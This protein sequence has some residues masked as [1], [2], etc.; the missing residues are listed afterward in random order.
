MTEKGSGT[1]LSARIGEG[2]GCGG[3]P[4]GTIHRSDETRQRPKG[5]RQRPSFQEW[6][7]WRDRGLP[8][9]PRGADS[10]EAEEVEEPEAVEVVTGDLV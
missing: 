8:E 10:D 2:S 6:Q 4:R 1:V 7:Y 9:D 5:Q 3:G